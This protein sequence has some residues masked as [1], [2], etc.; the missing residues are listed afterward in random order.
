MIEEELEVIKNTID[1][2]TTSEPSD[3]ASGLSLFI[4]ETQNFI[5]SNPQSY[6]ETFLFLGGGFFFSK[7][8]ENKCFELCTALGRATATS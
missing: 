8:I 4:Q 7:E 2:H 3:I 5:K 1:E 6:L